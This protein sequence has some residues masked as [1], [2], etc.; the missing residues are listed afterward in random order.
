MS[1][2]DSARIASYSAGMNG[3]PPTAQASKRF[4]SPAN[5]GDCRNCLSFDAVMSPSTAGF[6]LWMSLARRSALRFSSSSAN[7]TRM[8]FKSGGMMSSIE[9][10]KD[11]VAVCTT[12]SGMGVRV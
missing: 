9:A 1:K 10:S 4:I 5:A 12:L 11:T 7:I 8:P 2:S 3:S 6:S